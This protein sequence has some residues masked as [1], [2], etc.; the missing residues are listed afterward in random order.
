MIHTTCIPLAYLDHTLCIP[1]VYGSSPEPRVSP[2]QYWTVSHTNR[3]TQMKAVLYYRIL[4]TVAHL[5]QRLGV[6]LLR[7]NVGL[8]ASRAPEPALA[9]VTGQL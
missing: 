9:R 2:A 8:L 7:D 1:Y 6:V 4:A 3:L 5:K